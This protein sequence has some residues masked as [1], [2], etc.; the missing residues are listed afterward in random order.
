MI[1]ARQDTIQYTRNLSNKLSMQVAEYQNI[2]SVEHFHEKVKI[3]AP[4]R[5]A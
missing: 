3:A 5:H 1:V 2:I 4:I